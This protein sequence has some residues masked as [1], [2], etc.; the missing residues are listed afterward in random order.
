GQWNSYDI[1]CDGKT[2]TLFVNGLLQNK[3]ADV[4]PSSGPISLQSEGSPIEFRNIY[5]EPVTK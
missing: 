3:G 2:I 4:D 1:I 5:I